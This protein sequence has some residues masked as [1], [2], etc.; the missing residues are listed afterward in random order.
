MALY[1]VDKWMSWRIDDEGQR[2]VMANFVAEITQEVHTLDGINRTVTLTI[3][4]YQANPED[5]DGTMEPIKLPPVTVDA[6]S[7][8]GL[9]WVMPGWGVRAVIRP[10]TSI[11][12][13]LRTFIQMRSK[14]KI[15]TIYK[16]L[17][18]TDIG[19]NRTYLH[20]GGGINKNGNNP[21]VIVRL[22]FE[23]SR[24]D[25]TTKVEPVAGVKA[26]LDLLN[27]TRKDVT[28]PL[29]AGTLTPLFGAVD[30]GLHVS[31]RTGT[32]KS[33]LMSLFQSHYGAGM[34]ARHLPGSWSSTANALEAQAF[35]AA[36]AAFV[37]DDFVP[38]GTS[39]QVRA[40]QQTADKII[41]AQGNQAG[42]ARLTDMSDLRQ[43]MYP[44]G[45]ILSTGED[46]PE[47][48]SVRARLLIMEMSPGDIEADR[49][50]EAQQDRTFYPATVAGLV[51]FLAA[52]PVDLTPRV[53]ELRK[54]YVGIGHSRTPSMLAR[55]VATSEYF[56]DWCREIGAISDGEFASKR[57]EAKEAIEKAGSEQQ[58]YLE[59]ADPVDQFRAAIRQAIA[60][61]LGHF[62]TTNGGIPM[63]AEL[64][65]WTVERSS[66]EMPM[67]R[68]RGPAIGWVKWDDDEMYLDITVGYNVVKKVAGNEMTLSKQTMFKRLKDA[69][70]LLRA[71][72]ARQR[73]TIRITAENHP[74]NVLCLSLSQ[75][76]DMKE[77][78]NERK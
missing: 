16:H 23:L 43:T 25:L 53:E 64:L 73:N 33:E 60:A 35:L 19:K 41:R 47:G 76:L 34:D 74:R 15:T 9:S 78:P 28:W 54:E 50:T 2:E 52:N 1:E 58:Q 46:T 48:H 42:R 18:W 71:D 10:G 40:Y 62:R 75:T 13:D 32:F 6:E 3:E 51:Q 11:K 67:Y 8:A 49:L 59:D 72:E 17:G 26:T 63:H 77:K 68:S 30:F 29:L 65:G 5:K 4:G 69:G 39:W 36:N 7:F 20:A 31:G 55:L 27:L 38:T 66:G 14:P 56:L 44:R 37:I 57:R 45:I 70:A 24:Y 22:P 12:D 61:G 21:N